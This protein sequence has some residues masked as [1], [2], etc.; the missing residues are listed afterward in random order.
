[1]DT[2]AKAAPGPLAA[3]VAFASR[4]PG[5]VLAVLLGLHL[6]I[7]TVVPILVCPNLQLDLAENLALGKEW[8]LGYWKHPPLPWWLGDLTFRLTGDI[9]S[10][11]LLG[12]LAAVLCFY[13]VWLLAREMVDGITALIAVLALEG[14]HYYNFSVVKFGHDHLLLVFW[15]F[16]SLFFYRGI[17]RGRSVDWLIAGV[18]L[19]GAFWSKYSVLMMAATLGLILVIDPV[20]RQTW[21]TP[22][23]WV[24]G[25]AFALVIAPNVWWL[26]NNEFL[27]F[28]YAD[29]RA[30]LAAE[31]YDYIVFP[32]QW[33]GSQI[34]FTAPAIALVALLYFGGDRARTTAGERG[35]L[36]AF[37]LRYVA[38]I[39]L[40]PFL[41]STL[42]GT[43]LGRLPV[44][45]W[46]FPLWSFA[47]LAALMWLRPKTTLRLREW[48]AAGFLTVFIGFPVA[49]AGAE[50]FEP[51]IRDR[52]KATTFPGEVLAQA[53]TREWRERFGTPL[54][55]VGGTEFATNNV[56]VYSPD[57]P[58]VI[59]HGNPNLSPW[60][61]R[62]EL[63][64]YGAVLV[65]ETG[66]ATA[67]RWRGTFPNLEE[68]PT[69]VL[70]RQTLSPVAPAR[71]HYAFVPPRPR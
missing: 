3:V 69:L 27:P 63:A 13:G 39:A 15:P 18:L 22:G 47:P 37:N 53:I 14:I 38:A 52:T 33:I 46:G 23:P 49:Y 56:A 1:M 6:L 25:L 5:K 20:A 68:Q 12:P 41:V 60:I 55:Y 44:A 11:Y 71:V 2:V 45:M 30:Q 59:V 29:A 66:L 28:R 34:F 36:A 24:M 9:R 21:R 32:L 26:F 70:A 62:N 17:T 54:T 19:A 42:A 50:L 43:L 7:W 61:N 8:Q 48:F 58:H 4:E 65:W 57:R 35:G 40:G 16:I 51:L 67:D 31:W 64:R 10:M